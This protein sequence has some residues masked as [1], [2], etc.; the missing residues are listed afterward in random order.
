[1]LNIIKRKYAMQWTQIENDWEVF[2]AIISQNWNKISYQQLE[3]VAGNRARFSKTIQSTYGVGS[4]E[5]EQ[6]LSDWQDAQINIDGHFYT[7][8]PT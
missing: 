1:M 5:A 4:P 8:F 3:V 6:Q 7:V 2:K